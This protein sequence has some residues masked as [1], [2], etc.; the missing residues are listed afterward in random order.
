MEIQ[1][2]SNI[3]QWIADKGYSNKEISEILGVSLRSVQRWVAGDGFPD[4]ES[5]V[6]LCRV[7]NCDVYDL[8]D[9][10]NKGEVVNREEC[11]S[12]KDL[13]ALGFDGGLA[14]GLIKQV[15][16]EKSYHERLTADGKIKLIKK[17]E[18]RAMLNH[19]ADLIV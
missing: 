11:V 13:T 3:S 9:V 19:L 15:N 16:L 6:K 4:V 14:H 10:G 17:D 18:A 1:V 12:F 2:K 7:F 5:L 8:I